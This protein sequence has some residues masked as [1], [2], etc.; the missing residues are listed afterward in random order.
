MH[1]YCPLC[2]DE[3]TYEDIACGRVHVCPYT[4]TYV[5][6]CQSMF[7]CTEVTDTRATCRLPERH[8]HLGSALGVI[9]IR[10]SFSAYLPRTTLFN[11][12]FPFGTSLFQIVLQT[13]FLLLIQTLEKNKQTPITRLMYSALYDTRVIRNRVGRR[14]MLRQKNAEFPYLV[15]LRVG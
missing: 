15:I 8:I 1:A 12:V 3:T 5:R 9:L 4:H 11:H 14:A 2:T 13:N 6:M 10:I 7:G